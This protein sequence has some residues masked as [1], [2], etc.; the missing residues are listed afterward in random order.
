MHCKICRTALVAEAAAGKA[1][2]DAVA[3]AERVVEEVYPKCEPC[4]LSV[5]ARAAATA[6]C[7]HVVL[8][9]W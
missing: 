6:L 1:A 8:Q 2:D 5:R 3:T 9:F 7:S 4:F